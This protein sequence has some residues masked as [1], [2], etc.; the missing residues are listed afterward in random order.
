MIDVVAVI[1]DKDGGVKYVMSQYVDR[2]YEPAAPTVPASEFERNNL[3]FEPDPIKMAQW[4]YPTRWRLSA[5]RFQ[6]DVDLRRM[7][8][9]LRAPDGTATF[10]DTSDYEAWLVMTKFAE[11]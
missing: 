3:G 5:I 9:K 1:L 2:T 11:A 7:P 6:S 10:M 8:D 4:V